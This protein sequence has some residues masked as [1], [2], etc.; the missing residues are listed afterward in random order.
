M[1]FCTIILIYQLYNIF[2]IFYFKILIITQYKNARKIK[3]K[4]I[5]SS[6]FY[7]KP[8]FIF[9]LKY[10]MFITMENNIKIII[11]EEIIFNSHNYL[12]A[13]LNIF[14]GV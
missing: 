4:C 6:I 3:I 8:K 7:K 1:Q 2:I 14:A 13:K 9:A 11:D 5:T 10:Y 12:K